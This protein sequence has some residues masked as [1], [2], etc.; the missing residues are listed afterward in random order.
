MA[1]TTCEL[2]WL[3]FLL[4][5]MQVFIRPA[6]LLCD[7]Q[8][9]HHIEANPVYNRRTKHIELNCHVVREKIQDGQIITKFVPSH[10]QLA[11]VFTKAL[12]GNVFKKL[13]SKLNMLDIHAQ[14]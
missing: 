9:A 4:N 7:N 14:T 10:L 1:A 13:T 11:D 8:A 3:K 12:G 2:T 5:D 6:R